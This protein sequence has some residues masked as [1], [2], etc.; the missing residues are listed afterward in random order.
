LPLK[1]LKAEAIAE[2][3]LAVCFRNCQQNQDRS[4]EYTVL[5]DKSRAMQTINYYYID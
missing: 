3:Q 4:S 2:R 5:L 1:A